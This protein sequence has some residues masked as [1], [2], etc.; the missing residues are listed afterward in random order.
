MNLKC[1]YKALRFTFLPTLAVLLL[2]LVGFWSV[3]DLWNFIVSGSAGAVIVR[4]ILFLAEAGL[5]VYMYF[6]YLEKEMLNDVEAGSLQNTVRYDNY[7]QNCFKDLECYG[8]KI[9]VYNTESPKI[10]VIKLID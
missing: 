7:A 8:K 6:H 1:F 9:E 3:S 5:A 4:I 2:L 10:K